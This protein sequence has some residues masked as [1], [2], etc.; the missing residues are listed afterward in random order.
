MDDEK[1]F[2]DCFADDETAFE[3]MSN[4]NGC[5]PSSV[6]FGVDTVVGNWLN[7]G[8]FVVP[9]FCAENPPNMLL[10]L[11]FDGILKILS[12]FCSKAKL[13]PP[14]K[15]GGAALV[16]GLDPC[17]PLVDGSGVTVFGDNLDFGLIDCLGGGR[18]VGTLN[19]FSSSLLA[20]GLCGDLMR[21]STFACGRKKF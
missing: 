9:R 1:L 8:A 19:T 16:D 2:P 17:F 13:L 15:L 20:N 5:L 18:A 12:D 14:N 11:P 21:A 7:D 6:S 10:A 3:K 4:E